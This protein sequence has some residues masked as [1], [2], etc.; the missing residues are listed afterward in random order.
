MNIKIPLGHF[1]KSQVLKIQMFNNI[2]SNNYNL[3]GNSLIEIYT[4]LIIT[5]PDCNYKVAALI[6]TLTTYFAG[7]TAFIFLNPY[8]N[9]TLSGQILFI[10]YYYCILGRVIEMCISVNRFDS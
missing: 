9:T 4:Y 3:T 10:N 5:L 6:D 1:S 8:N 2:S 7:K